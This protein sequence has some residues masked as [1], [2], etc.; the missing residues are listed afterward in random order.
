M[1][2]YNRDLEKMFDDS[3]NDKYID[4]SYYKKDF[5]S[6]FG[7][8]TKDINSSVELASMFDD[9]SGL[10]DFYLDACMGEIVKSNDKKVLV[11]TCGIA[12]CTGVIFYNR[13]KKQ[14]VCCHCASGQVSSLPLEALKEF[15]DAPG[16]IEYQFI[17][18][19]DVE[20]DYK[21]S[22]NVN[23]AITYLIDNCPHNLYLISSNLVNPKLYNDGNPSYEFA[24]DANSGKDV[25]HF[26]H[27]RSSFVSDGKYY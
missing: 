13:M 21:A 19:P 15:G 4:N 26:I 6:G 23:D 16:I 17:P 10:K 18:G 25:T 24:F 9:F 7:E 8:K 12:T 14:A 1:E 27:T 5:S 11:G 3:N 22:K 2:K 20:S